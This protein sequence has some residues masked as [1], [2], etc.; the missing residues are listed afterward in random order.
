LDWPI[1]HSSILDR[2]SESL[3]SLNRQSPNNRPISR[4]PD[5]QSPNGPVP[6]RL[7]LYNRPVRPFLK[8]AGG[9]RQLL[10]RIRPFYPPTFGTYHEPFLGSGAVFF[11]LVDRG[12][13]ESRPAILTDEN[14][15]L[16]GTWLRVRDSVEDLVGSL[17]RLA[18]GHEQSGAAHYRRVR[19]RLFNPARVAWQAAG[20]PTSEYGPDLAAML[21]YLNRTGYNGLFRVNRAGAFNVPP[22]RYV[23]PRI[24]DAGLL[25]AVSATVNRGGIEVALAPFES[26]LDRVAPGDFVY[27][28]P[29]YAP[30]STTASF[31]SYTARG[32]GDAD[33]ARVQHVVLEL[34]A[35]GVHVL[36]SNSSAPL[37]VDLFERAE[38]RAAGLRVHR[39]T[40]RRAINTRADRRGL[41]DELLVTTA[42]AHADL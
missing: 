38:A 4:S 13:L 7:R 2:Q 33:Q 39:V 42:A 28:D 29:P 19:D 23:R 18:R 20:S 8:W 9:K 6:R 35:R 22:G 21:I 10:P 24:A 15:D 34:A 40:A 11:D 25:R 27:L 26:V 30:L 14:P 17:E 31:R 5:H 12:A 32:F 16:I 36:L 3:K 41:V 1:D 37:V